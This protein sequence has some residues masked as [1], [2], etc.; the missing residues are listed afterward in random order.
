MFFRVV[1]LT[2][3]WFCA[4]IMTEAAEITVRV[5]LFRCD[6]SQFAEEEGGLDRDEGPAEE[7]VFELINSDRAPTPVYSS[8]LRLEHGDRIERVTEL[9]NGK[10]RL[11]FEAN[12]N[13][14]NCVLKDLTLEFSEHEGERLVEQLRIFSAKTR[15]PK[16]EPNLISL[17]AAGP[18]RT[19]D[20][21]RHLTY[22]FCIVSVVSE[23]FVAKAYG[24]REQK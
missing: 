21:G 12:L 3:C 18:G 2:A 9:A 6:E 20:G 13:D 5:Q 15:V 1:L 24:K 22:T 23:K 10:V 7:A 16:S 14:E 19:V 4:T 8:E 17:S 11:A